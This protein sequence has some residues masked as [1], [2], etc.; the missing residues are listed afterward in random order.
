MVLAVCMTHHERHKRGEQTGKTSQDSTIAESHLRF[1][2][3]QN[4]FNYLAGIGKLAAEK[5]SQTCHLLANNQRLWS[6]PFD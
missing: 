1:V 5:V 2:W 4:Q 6:F 3:P